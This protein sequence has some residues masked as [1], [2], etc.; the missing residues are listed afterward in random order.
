MGLLIQ[1]K[2]KLWPNTLKFDFFT[3][4][5]YKY[6]LGIS[7]MP[8]KNKL[9]GKKK[10]PLA[11]PDIREILV[12]TKINDIIYY[13]NPKKDGYIYD[14]DA[15]KVGINTGEEYHFFADDIE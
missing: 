13:V 9:H 2:M 8:K 3:F 10:T 15:F 4:Y 12:K 1:K 7:N 14:K 5:F 6:I 11:P